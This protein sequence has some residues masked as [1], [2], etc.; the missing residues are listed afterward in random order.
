MARSCQRFTVS[1]QRALSRDVLRPSVELPSDYVNWSTDVNPDDLVNLADNPPGGDEETRREALMK[2]ASARIAQASKDIYT[3]TRFPDFVVL[4]VK[5][6]S[7]SSILLIV[8]VKALNVAE[9][10]SEL[11]YEAAYEEV[12]SA[13]NQVITQAKFAFD[14]HKEQ[15]RMFV[16]RAPGDYWHLMELRREDLMPLPVH[17]CGI[18]I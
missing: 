16:I 9:E 10:D 8:E 18:K 13:Y 15:D 3:E 6:R 7:A 14:L 4:F 17:P 11:E 12:W 1:P 5:G 2:G